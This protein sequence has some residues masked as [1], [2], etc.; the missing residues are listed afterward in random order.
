M[1][2][3][4]QASSSSKHVANRTIRLCKSYMVDLQENSPVEGV[5]SSH[6]LNKLQPVHLNFF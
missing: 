3:N 2:Q 6:I 4:K 5:L 1:E